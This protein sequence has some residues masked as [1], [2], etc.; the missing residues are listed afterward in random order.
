[1]SVVDGQD[2]RDMATTL[3][4]TMMDGRKFS[5][6]VTAFMGTPERPLDRAGLWEKF[7][8]LT[9]AYPRADMERLFERIQGVEKEPNLDWLAV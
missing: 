2:N 1:M 6:H 5:K 3:T 9:S 7:N 8:L 4:V